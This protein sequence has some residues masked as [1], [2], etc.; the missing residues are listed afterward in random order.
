MKLDEIYEKIT[1][2]ER[3]ASRSVE[4]ERA[5]SE[6]RRANARARAEK[7]LAAAVEGYWKQADE[8]IAREKERAGREAEA[9]REKGTA[10]LSG[11]RDSTAARMD[12]AV[13][14]ILKRLMDE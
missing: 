7:E 6:K 3:E 4:E 2:A 12:D 11:L 1:G 14:S 5:L 9:I 10:R 13:S 8:A